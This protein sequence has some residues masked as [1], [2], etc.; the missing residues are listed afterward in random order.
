MVLWFDTTMLFL[1]E[2]EIRG[3][4]TLAEAIP[5]VEESFVAYTRK[6]ANVPGVIHLDVPER[7]GEVHVKGA[8][9][10]GAREFVIK[11]A[12]GFFQN[13]ASNLP[14]GSG[15]MMVFS[16]E[17]GFPEGLLLDNAYLTDLRTA[18]AGAVAAKHMANVDVEQ[19]AVLGA[20]VQGRLQ[21]EALSCVRKFSRVKVYDHNTT[22]IV[23]YLSDMRGRVDAELL[24]ASTVEEA[25][26][27]SRIVV[28]CTPSRQ[29]LVKAGW[30]EPGT[31]ITA[32][33]SDGADKQE[34]EAQVLARAVRVI[35]DSLSQCAKFG[36]IHHALEAG[37][38]RLE[39]VTGELGQ[40]VCGDIPGRVTANEVTVCDLTGVGVQD[41]AIAGLVYRRARERGLGREL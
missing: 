2:N 9:L 22:N 28:T 41:A 24:A 34:L 39:N 13:R 12:T 40:V 19:V 4:V 26:R 11:V 37:L 23:R 1:N 21:L 36:E 10:F 15:L 14:P 33:G 20:G 29:P 18:A 35:A 5:V 30:V 17:T 7:Q 16:A 31:H 32:M 3:A 6:T 8:Y 25:L 27:G 38:M